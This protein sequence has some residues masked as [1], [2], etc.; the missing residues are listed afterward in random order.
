MMPK[1][2]LERPATT[3]RTPEGRESWKGA[4]NQV[5][6]TLEWALDFMEVEEVIELLARVSQSSL[7]EEN[8]ISEALLLK[9]YHERSASKI[10]N[11]LPEDAN[12]G[13]Q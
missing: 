7:V 9:K 10:D 8:T 5:K 2:K 1:T 3:D 12:I 4:Q 6:G 13:E 11:K